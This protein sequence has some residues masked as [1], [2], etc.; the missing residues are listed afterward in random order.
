MPLATLPP[1]RTSRTSCGRRLSTALTMEAA[2]CAPECLCCTNAPFRRFRV[3][4][5]QLSGPAAAAAAAASEPAAAASEPADRWAKWRAVEARIEAGE[6]ILMDGGTGTEVERR[7]KEKGDPT[8]VNVTGWSCAQ[9]LLHP[10]VCEE[11][12]AAY[13]KLGSE[14]VIAN[15]YASNRMILDRAGYGEQIQQVHASACGAA[16]AARTSTATSEDALVVGSIS[17]HPPLIVE[18]GGSLGALSDGAEAPTTDTTP[19]AA[20]TGEA[21]APEL[22]TFPAPDV[23]I[24]AFREQA[25]LLAAAGVDA[26]FCEMLTRKDVSLRV[27][28]AALTVG[29]PVFVGFV[30]KVDMT[31]EELNEPARIAGG[32]RIESMVAEVLA[33]PGAAEGIAGFHIHH[34]KIWATLH[35]CNAVR[36]AGWTGVLGCYPDHGDVSP[37]YSATPSVCAFVRWCLCVCVAFYFRCSGLIV[38]SVR[39][40]LARSL[41]CHTGSSTSY[42]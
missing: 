39:A 16:M 40:V 22:D 13:Y 21:I 6:V 25:E 18:G 30:C 3:L 42:R 12:H 41:R 15:T 36:S 14:V 23:Q 37:S 1:R 27:V 24:A 19:K 35:A 17:A 31:W 32:S 29:L 20:T 7:V 11:V 26:I 10:D 2:P 33:L 38:S 28:E 4:S 5:T 34:T 9:A 8:A